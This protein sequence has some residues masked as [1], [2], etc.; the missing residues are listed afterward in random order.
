[1]AII[2][3]IVLMMKGN[4]VCIHDWISIRSG[5]AFQREGK[6]QFWAFTS[7]GYHS[8]LVNVG[9]TTENYK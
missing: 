7:C 5:R 8:T 2:Y 6:P 4:V 9:N 1:M 3:T